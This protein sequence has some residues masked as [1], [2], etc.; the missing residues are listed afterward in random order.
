MKQAHMNATT[1]LESADELHSALWDGELDDFE[2]RKLLGGM[3]TAQRELWAEYAMIGDALRGVGTSRSGFM[4]RFE[5]ALASE[6]T[7]LAPVAARKPV[8]APYL[9]TAAAAAMVA[10]TWTV[11]TAAPTDV[12]GQPQWMAQQPATSQPVAANEYQPGA[13]DLESYMEAHQDFAY[14]VVS[15]PDLTVERVSLTEVRP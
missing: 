11:W 2:A 13:G 14:A 5:T 7:I 10:I 12:S 4:Q 1:P 3:D 15:V 6:P 8:V 9:W